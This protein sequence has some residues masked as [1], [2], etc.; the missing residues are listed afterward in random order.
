[1][2]HRWTDADAIKLIEL[3][4]TYHFL[5]DSN[6]RLYKNHMARTKAYE[7]IMEQ[8]NKPNITVQ[9][10]RCKIKNLRSSYYQEVKKV[11]RAQDLGLEYTPT[12]PWFDYVKDIMDTVVHHQTVNLMPTFTCLFIIT[13]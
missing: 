12:L 3:Y 7:S 8:M 11:S 2:A 1:M 4:K 13:Y 10:I 5:W 6:H 9:D